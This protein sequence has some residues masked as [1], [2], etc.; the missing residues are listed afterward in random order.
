[1]KRKGG[2]ASI[3][4]R[5]SGAINIETS[6]HQWQHNGDS[7]TQLADGSMGIEM[8]SAVRENGHPGLETGLGNG[9]GVY[10]ARTKGI[11]KVTAEVYSN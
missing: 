5:A 9:H 6:I 4:P 3:R 11:H 7:Q 10:D 8:S 2:S 1:M